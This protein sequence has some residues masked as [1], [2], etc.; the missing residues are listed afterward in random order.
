M[1][2]S[3]DRFALVTS[4]NQFKIGV[5]KYCCTHGCMSMIGNKKL[6]SLR[7]YYFSLTGDEQDTYL[8]AKMQM[9]KDIW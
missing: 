5:N 6:W 3:R 1:S 2:K 8:T 7:H 4:E 9:V